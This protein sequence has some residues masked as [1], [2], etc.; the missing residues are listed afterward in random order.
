MP[1]LSGIIDIDQIISN[2]IVAAKLAEETLKD[3]EGE[4]DIK[5]TDIHAAIDD[6]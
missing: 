4:A 3:F 1:Y 2:Q 5:M 6:A